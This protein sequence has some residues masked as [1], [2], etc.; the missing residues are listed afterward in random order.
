M[1]KRTNNCPQK[2]YTETKDLA[3]RT[4]LKTGVEVRCSGR[5]NS[6][7]STC[8]ARRVTIVK[9]PATWKCLQQTEHIRG[10]L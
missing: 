10:H 5:V 3:T 4:P 6:S 7:C 8:D 2:H 9:K 1:G